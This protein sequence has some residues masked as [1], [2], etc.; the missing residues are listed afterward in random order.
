MFVV[1]GTTIEVCSWDTASF[2]ADLSLW[3]V[4]DVTDMSG[5]FSDMVD[6]NSDLSSWDVSSVTDM[7]NMFQNAASF[8][9]DLSR[10]N[11]EKVMNMNGI[12]QGATSL[13]VCNRGSICRSWGSRRPND[14]ETTSYPDCSGTQFECDVLCTT[15]TLAHSC[16]LLIRISFL[17]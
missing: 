15:P 16:S 8:N 11:V 17:S 12:F 9:S 7:A 10:W 1:G 4:Q 5:A 2:T 14:C 3:N 13:D 6:F